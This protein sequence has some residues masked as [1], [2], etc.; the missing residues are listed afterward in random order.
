[1]RD[2]DGPPRPGTKRISA[3]T[4]EPGVGDRRAVAKK[5]VIERLKTLAP[6]LVASGAIV[7]ARRSSLEPDPPSRRPKRPSTQK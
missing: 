2:G 5:K 1:M 7:N 4:I 3:R 6:S